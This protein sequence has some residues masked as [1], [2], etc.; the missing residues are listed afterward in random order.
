LVAQTTRT[1]LLP[2][3]SQNTPRTCVALYTPSSSVEH[4]FV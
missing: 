4:E 2:E 1:A 3:S